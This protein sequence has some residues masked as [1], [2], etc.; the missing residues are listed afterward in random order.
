MNIENLTSIEDLEQLLQGNKAIAF[1]ILGDNKLCLS[2]M[3]GA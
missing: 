2:A 1:T 3:S